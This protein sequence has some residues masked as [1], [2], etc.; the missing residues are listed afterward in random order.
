MEKMYSFTFIQREK[1]DRITQTKKKTL[2]K[3]GANRMTQ[4]FNIIVC[5]HVLFDVRVFFYWMIL[6]SIR[7]CDQLN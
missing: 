3:S 4:S 1:I 2:R 5:V 7:C 6:D